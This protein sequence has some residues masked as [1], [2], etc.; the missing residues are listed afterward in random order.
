MA[1]INGKSQTSEASQELK[2]PTRLKNNRPE[3]TGAKKTEMSDMI[4]PDM[5]EIETLP[6]IS[7]KSKLRKFTVKEQPE[8]KHLSVDING[9]TKAA[10]LPGA[11]RKLRSKGTSQEPKSSTLLMDNRSK[12]SKTLDSFRNAVREAMSRMGFKKAREAEKLE[13]N[14]EKGKSYKHRVIAL[15]YCFSLADY[16]VAEGRKYD[17]APD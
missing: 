9:R 16:L 7:V 4:F 10:T 15:L 5:E 13:K 17:N 12:K 2:L 8:E 1:P 14:V 3:E 11:S 6:E